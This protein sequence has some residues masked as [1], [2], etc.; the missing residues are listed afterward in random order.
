MLVAALLAVGLI[1]LLSA[2]A[3][4]VMPQ[5]T[6]NPAG[7]EARKINSLFWLVFWI[8]VAV[9]VLVEGLIVVAMVKFRRRPGAGIP[10]QVH[11]NKGLEIG[12]TIAPAVILLAISI[13]TVGTIF[14][15]SRKPPHSLDITVT[16]HQW[17]WQVEYPGLRVTTAN[18]IHIPVGRPVYVAVTSADVIH[19]F[20][21]PRLAGKQD[22]EPGRT[23]HVTLEA[24][25]PGTYLG[26]CA[27]YCG[28][29][30][31]NMRMRVIA[32]TDGDFQAWAD[33]ESRPAQVA[34]T[35]LA[36]QGAD[37]FANGK[38]AGAQQCVACHTVSGIPNAGGV[39]G[40][41]LTHFGNRT[42]FAGSIFPN[43]RA[44]LEAWLRDP[45]AIKPGADMPNLGLTQEQINALIAFL[46]SLK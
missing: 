25:Q 40:P 3:K 39:I 17:W 6:L 20:W 7:P 46:E 36:A 18:E 1:F 35:G 8:A 11:G 13:P 12:W 22:L 33:A 2:C 29:S 14:S 37:L 27:E 43:D 15:L 19:S 26:Q 45:P 23:N 21:I 38:F 41:D 24:D 10:K 4:T 5:D 31:A 42:T 28:L 34:T 16:G 9:F 32:Q 30:H 44:H